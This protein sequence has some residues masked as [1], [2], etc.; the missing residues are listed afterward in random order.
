MPVLSQASRVEIYSHREALETSK[1][2]G[3]VPKITCDKTYYRRGI[4]EELL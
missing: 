3:V 4:G 2:L 1:V